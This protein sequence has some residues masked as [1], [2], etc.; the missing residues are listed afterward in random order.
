[1]VL[2]R[3]IVDI[4]ATPLTLEELLAMAQAEEAEIVLVQGDK[5]LGRFRSPTPEDAAVIMAER[6]KQERVRRFQKA[7]REIGE[8]VAELGLTEEQL[9]EKLDEVRQRMYEE[10]YRGELPE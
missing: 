8:A 3:H 7:A 2:V 10:N 4:Q 1:M 6:E 9:M 5:A